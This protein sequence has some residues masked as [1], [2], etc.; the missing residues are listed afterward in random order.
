MLG[1]YSSISGRL[2]QDTAGQNA[3]VDHADMRGLVTDW[4][5]LHRGAGLSLVSGIIDRECPFGIIRLADADLAR[6]RVLHTGPT[7]P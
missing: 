7:L 2:G 5:S 4:T 1:V 3:M 6:T